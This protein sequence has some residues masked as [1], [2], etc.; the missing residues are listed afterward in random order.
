MIV[1]VAASLPRRPG[2]PPYRIGPMRV[3][4]LLFGLGCIL[5]GGYLLLVVLAFASIIDPDLQGN[6]WW[7][8]FLLRVF[9][10]GGEG[11][12]FCLLL[13]VG[14]VWLVRL[15]PRYEQRKKPQRESWAE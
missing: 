10:Q 15:S 12:G 11:T 4:M 6:A 5:V 8:E 13:I 9:I 7:K 2:F 3:L 14:G 1:T